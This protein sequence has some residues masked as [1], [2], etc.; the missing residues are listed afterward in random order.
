MCLR[1]STTMKLRV[2]RSPEDP[3]KRP[4]SVAM[5]EIASAQAGSGRSRTEYFA[6]NVAISF[7]LPLRLTIQRAF[8]TK[9]AKFVE[10]D[11]KI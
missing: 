2:R 9:C 4:C 10:E 6:F 8:A 1:R 5:K 7:Q 11:L 3:R